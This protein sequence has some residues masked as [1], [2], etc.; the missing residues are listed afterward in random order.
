MKIKTLLLTSAATLLLAAGSASANLIAVWDFNDE[1]TGTFGG[2]TTFSADDGTQSASASLF[3]PAA[4]GSSDARIDSNGTTLNAVGSTVAGNNLQTRR[5]SRWDNQSF[6]LSFNMTGL[7]DV[8]L[9]FD[10]YRLFSDPTRAAPSG[11]NVFY[12]TDG[13]NFTNANTTLT[14]DTTGYS[15]LTFS[16]GSVLDNEATAFIRLTFLA[17][18]TGNTGDGGAGV[19]F[20]N[21]Q[22]NT[23]VIPEP[24]TYAALFGIA[25]LG[26]VLYRRRKR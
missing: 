8:E 1:T 3:L 17:D 4:G 21:I 16:A 20:D 24:T 22:L 26:L 23:A 14:F 6:D 25:A 10:A 19:R 12:S 18:A 2:A 9:S 11:F 15:T 5:G 7:Q 13:T